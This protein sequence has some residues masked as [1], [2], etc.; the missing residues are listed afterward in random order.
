M[1]T[2]KADYLLIF[3]DGDVEPC[4]EEVCVT[5]TQSVVPVTQGLLYLSVRVSMATPVLSQGLRQSATALLTLSH[6]DFVSRTTELLFSWSLGG[7]V[8]PGAPADPEGESTARQNLAG[9]SLQWFHV[10]SPGSQQDFIIR[11]QIPPKKKIMLL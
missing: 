6:V 3:Q 7:L 11:I 4:P 9:L 5:L 1:A 8:V 10:S 2:L